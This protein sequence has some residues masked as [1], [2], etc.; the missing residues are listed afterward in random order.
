MLG[1]SPVDDGAHELTPFTVV[2][3]CPFVGEG[4]ICDGEMF[5]AKA[6]TEIATVSPQYLSFINMLLAQKVC[7]PAVVPPQRSPVPAR[8]P[9]QAN[10]PRPPP[11]E[12]CPRR[13][14]TRAAPSA[15]LR[16]WSSGKLCSHRPPCRSAVR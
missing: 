12:S 7:P 1:G 10:I 11:K 14:T 3:T 2:S 13:C 9:E 16:C 5:C 15:A 6:E 4:L 8:S